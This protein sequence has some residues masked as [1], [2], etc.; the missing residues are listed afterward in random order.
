MLKGVINYMNKKAQW[1]GFRKWSIITFELKKVEIESK[2]NLQI[3]ENTNIKKTIDEEE[4]EYCKTIQQLQA[5]TSKLN[6]EKNKNKLQYQKAIEI[7]KIRMQ[8]NVVVDRRRLILTTWNNFVQK[9]KSSCDKIFQILER[10]IKI[11]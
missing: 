4:E 2:I 5:E 7:L 10:N 6:T 9:E 3:T 8:N 1:Q 11:N